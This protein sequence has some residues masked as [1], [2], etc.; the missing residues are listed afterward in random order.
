MTKESISIL[1]IEDSSEYADLVQLWLAQSSGTDFTLNWADSLESGLRRLR[2]GGIHVVLL[3]LGLPDS[4]GYE[5][6]EKTLEAAS[7]IP[8]IVWSS[9]DSESLA[10]RTIQ[11]G[12]Q[13]YLVKSTCTAEALFRAVRYAVVRHET[14]SRATGQAAQSQGRVLGIIGAKGGVGATSVACKLA[15]ELRRQTAETTVLLDLDLDSGIAG[16]LLNLESRYTIL[17]AVKNLHRLDANCWD[18][19]VAKDRGGLHIAPSPSLHG[20]DA[21]DPDGLRVV[22]N[23][24]RTIYRWTVLDLGRLSKLSLSLL[25]KEDEI[26]LITST[27][28]PS[29]FEV[30]RIITS[31]TSTG[32]DLG[33]LK[34]IVNHL[35][36]RSELSTSELNRLFGVAVYGDLPNATADFQDA[37]GVFR[38][39]HDGSAF[40]KG[41]T[42]LARKLAGLPESKPTGPLSRITSLWRGGSAENHALT[43]GEA[44]RG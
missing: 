22:L 12:A 42:S 6:F 2:E 44:L 3:D 36:P 29:L 41:M 32:F 38:L 27:A 23:F 40:H 30:K 18:T 9:L 7:T 10:L 37:Y 17:D 15:L 25:D 11:G 28:V 33:R 8:I 19:L 1:L 20:L 21:L 4:S 35:T 34:L 5:T 43:T 16:F 39:P 14:S 26:C 31:L 13:D 24:V